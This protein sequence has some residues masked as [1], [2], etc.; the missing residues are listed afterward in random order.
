MTPIR[1]K[2]LAYWKSALLDMME[3]Y[4][5]TGAQEFK[6]AIGFARRKVIRMETRAFHRQHKT[7][8]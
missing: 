8:K 1:I 4:R 6:D 7:A 3:A 5:T 2:D